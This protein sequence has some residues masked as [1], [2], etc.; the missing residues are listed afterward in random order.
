MD[1]DTPDLPAFSALARN[2][3]CW[4]LVDEA[5]S[6]GVLGKTGRGI[7]EHFGM[8]ADAADFWMGTLSKTLSGC[9][10]YIAGKRDLIAYL[11]LAAPGFVYSVGMSPP[12][13]AAALAS[14]DIMRQEPWRVERLNT[15]AR[16]FRD[17]ARAAGL[18]TGT[19]DGHG[20][21][22]VITGS[23]IV[24]ARLADA[25]FRRKINVQPILHPAVPER[26]ARLR[27]FMS[28]EHTEAQIDA[29]VAALA[30]AMPIVAAQK[31]DFAALA[32]KISRLRS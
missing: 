5:H 7:A 21:V 19:S 17:K 24:A 10:G 15:A 4:L 8:N 14:L 28:S 3:G 1:G 26:S 22:P 16:V 18:D 30:E 20:I 32:L 11:K 27:F 12:V 6:V 13:A 31:V 9:G 29:T 2:N 23:S 25:M